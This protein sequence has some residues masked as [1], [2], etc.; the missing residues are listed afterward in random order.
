MKCEVGRCAGEGLQMLLGSQQTGDRLSSTDP[1]T[2]IVYPWYGDRGIDLRECTTTPLAEDEVCTARCAPGYGPTS[3]AVTAQNFT[4]KAVQG[5]DPW[6]YYD[7]VGVGC[8]ATANDRNTPAGGGTKD[9][10][11][12][13]GDPA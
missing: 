1:F 11:K 13:L 6:S 8:L 9:S 4:C 2:G 3:M 5:T 10:L 7:V 12:A